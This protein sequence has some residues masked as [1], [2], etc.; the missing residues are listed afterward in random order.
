MD[1]EISDGAVSGFDGDFAINENAK[2]RFMARK[3]P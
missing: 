3:Y 2:E 1:S